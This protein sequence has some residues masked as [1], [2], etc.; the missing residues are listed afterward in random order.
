MLD[1]QLRFETL[2]TRQLLAA[3]PLTTLAVS[4]EGLLGET[5]TLSVGFSNN[6]PTDAGFGPYID[7]RLPATG[8]DGAGTELDDG[9]TFSGATY[10]GQPVGA[11]V[12]TFDT[13]G[14]AVHPLARDSSGNPVVVSGTPG[15]QLV[16]LEL[17]FGSYTPGQPVSNV[18]IT[19]DMSPLA[20][21]DTPLVVEARGGFRFGND[22][23]DNPTTDPSLLES[24]FHS[25]LVTPSVYRLS[26]TYHGPEDETA[27]GPNYPRQYTVSV[28]LADG[29]TLTSLELTDVLSDNLQFVSIDSTLVHGTPVVTEVLNTPSTLTP[30]GTLT[31]RFASVTGT[32]AGN[33]ASMTFTFY[34]PQL[35]AA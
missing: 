5:T 28:D 11:T 18:D 30:G 31:R 26:K 3:I 21:A 9:L 1:R 7:L 20:D 15:D 4:N 33:D 23:L 6:S 17:P 24:P 8:T 16:V 2:E 14:T 19:V 10:L 35:D 27:T 12:L 22:P 32:S 29:A 25:A 13:L 34:V